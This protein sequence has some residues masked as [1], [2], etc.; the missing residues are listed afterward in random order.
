[1]A[2]FKG[3]SKFQW[4]K[5]K[6]RR[7]IGEAAADALKKAGADCRRTSQ[8]QMRGGSQPTGKK[9]PGTPKLWKVG[10][11]SGGIPM[12]AAVYQVP[13]ANKVTSWAP[14]AFLR[15]DIQYDYDYRTSS[16]VVGPSKA[17]WLNQLHEFGG[18]VRVFFNSYTK[19]PV[20]EFRMKKL[21]S[22]MVAGRAGAY[23]GWLSNKPM[24]NS[25]SLGVRSVAPRPYM[26]A[27]LDAMKHRIPQ[28]FRNKLGGTAA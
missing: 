10:E 25:I 26:K 11:R 20:S 22:R 24:G 8:R 15:N 3:S 4:N 5:G 16:V 18:A 23:V 1:M 12:V 6:L 27:G 28:Q 13:A 7:L 17:P 19:G 14:K 21:P 2:R 9:S